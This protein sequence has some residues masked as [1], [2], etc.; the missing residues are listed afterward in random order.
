MALQETSDNG[1]AGQHH[2]RDCGVFF[3][4]VKSLE[5][6]L[7]YHKENLLSKWA[8]QAAAAAA[9]S[10]GDSENNNVKRREFQT[11]PADS[12]VLPTGPGRPNS[13]TGYPGSSSPFP[14][15]QTPQSYASAP[16]P[17]QNDAPSNPG[18]SP[19]STSYGYS[20]GGEPYSLPYNGYTRSPRSHPG[21]YPDQPQEGGYILGGPP[22]DTTPHSPSS[23][24]SFRFF[25]KTCYP[26]DKNGV[27]SSSPNTCEKC[28]CVCE[29]P[30]ALQE[31]I[32]TSHPTYGHVSAF[33]APE[34]FYKQEPAHD[35]PDI[36]DLD[37]QQKFRP[38]EEDSG[39]LPPVA[40]PHSVSA[41]LNPWPHG[42]FPPY[43]VSSSNP[44]PFQNGSNYPPESFSPPNVPTNPPIPNATS[45]KPASAGSGKGDSWKSNEARRPKTYNC[46]ACNKWFTSSGHLKRH[47]NTTLHKNAV[48][49]SGGPDPAT[50]PISSHHHPNRDP[51]YIHSSKTPPGVPNPPPNMGSAPKAKKAKSMSPQ[52]DQGTSSPALSS[53]N[54]GDSSRSGFGNFDIPQPQAPSAQPA[55]DNGFAPAPEHFDYYRYENRLQQQQNST[56]QIAAQPPNYQAGLSASPSGGLPIYP[57]SLHSLHTPN[58]LTYMGE[59]ITMPV[60]NVQQLQALGLPTT[61]LYTNSLII[62]GS[63]RDPLPS[64]SQLVPEANYKEF[65]I[66][67][68]CEDY[69]YIKQE[70]VLKQE[71]IEIVNVKQ[72][73]LMEEDFPRSDSR[74]PASFEFVNVEETKLTGYQELE[75]VLSEPSPPSSPVQFPT[76]TNVEPEPPTVKS[77]KKRK[78]RPEVLS[79]NHVTSTGSP[80]PVI[81]CDE[82]DKSFNRI[83]YLTQHNKCFHSGVKPFKCERCGKRF[84]TE[85]RARDHERKHG[86]VKPYRCEVCPKSFN[87][88]TDLRRHLCLHSGHKPFGCTA[89]GKGFIRKD[90]ML[91][92]MDTHTNN[93]RR[94]VPQQSEGLPAKMDSRTVVSAELK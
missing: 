54:E 65:Y 47:Y 32:K 89:C 41:M 77:P 34:N 29:S 19:S 90:H 71:E 25:N 70:M 1:R 12:T 13:T 92:H 5:V 61:T 48:K 86:G 93:R 58:H 72:E 17:Y 42:K 4:S 9:H 57:P 74:E 55:F 69:G 94:I 91:K 37:C 63:P 64:F 85:A 81:R 40:N 53:A 39:S 21:F 20:N 26:L 33:Q 31:H 28:G 68:G 66:P 84:H 73:P 56:N 60:E 7:Q 83:C 43:H 2:C 67:Q 79:S 15:P 78:K 49:Q 62:T 35:S 38:P 18:P 82:C 24:S 23:S 11:A 50:M 22:P 46:S 88:K 52:G 16:S 30:S 80:K 10:A 14:H 51:S 27:S 75:A 59:N 8:N 36:L 6:H 3:D 76:S 44:Q 87:H 45:P